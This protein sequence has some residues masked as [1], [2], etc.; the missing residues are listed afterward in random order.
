MNLPEIGMRPNQ[1]QSIEARRFFCL[2][3]ELSGQKVQTSESIEGE[4]RAGSYRIDGFVHRPG[5]K[6]LAIEYYGCAFHG[7]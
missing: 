5:K 3:S 2:Y 7:F 6:S 1:I 4:H